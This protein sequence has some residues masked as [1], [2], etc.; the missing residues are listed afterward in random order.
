[1]S[2]AK[3]GGVVEAADGASWRGAGA[4]GPMAAPGRDHAIR[5]VF[6]SRDEQGRSRA[7]Y[8]ELDRV[9]HTT[10]LVFGDRLLLDLGTLGAF[11]DSGVVPCS[12]VEH[13]GRHYLF[14]AGWNLG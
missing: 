13:G 12:L 8:A 6:G 9:E 2:W 4:M 14:Y 3:L 1:M 10:A 11:D 7:A 5:L